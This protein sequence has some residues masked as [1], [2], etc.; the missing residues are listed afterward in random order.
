MKRLAFLYLRFRRGLLPFVSLDSPE[1]RLFHHFSLHIFNLS[2]FLSFSCFCI[3]GLPIKNPIFSLV[4]THCTISLHFISS[5]CLKAIFLRHN[6]SPPSTIILKCIS[7][8]TVCYM[9]F[10]SLQ[11][12]F[13]HSYSYCL[14]S[15]LS[16]AYLLTVEH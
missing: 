10:V 5:S 4:I 14:C 2:D 11:F 9:S 6:H 8:Q 13:V 16:V 15:R 1:F 12:A 7:S 3:F